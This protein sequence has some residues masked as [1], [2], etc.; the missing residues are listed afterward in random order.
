[1]RAKV[2]E[3][4]N[5]KIQEALKAA[6]EEGV[7]KTLEKFSICRATLYNWA[8]KMGAPVSLE[9][10]N[11]GQSVTVNV[12]H[13]GKKRKIVFWKKQVKPPKEKKV[14][15]KKEKPKKEKVKRRKT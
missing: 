12:E 4:S 1:M 15:V 13:K 14:R 11:N 9:N 7:K 5:E 6:N 2:T 8:A 3:H 10:S